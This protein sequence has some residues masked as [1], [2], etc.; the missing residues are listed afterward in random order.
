ME[1]RK[2]EIQ[3]LLTSFVACLQPIIGYYRGVDGAD[4]LKHFTD[5][6]H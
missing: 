2:N 3:A 6:Q 1:D 4:V 5:F